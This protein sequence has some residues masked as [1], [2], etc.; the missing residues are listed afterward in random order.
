MKTLAR[1]GV[2]G[3]VIPAPGGL[4]ATRTKRAQ[5]IARR[6]WS[7]FD[8]L[9]TIRKAANEA[10]YQRRCA[11]RSD[12]VIFEVAHVNIDGNAILRLRFCAHAARRAV[13]TIC[14]SCDPGQPSLRR[15]RIKQAVTVG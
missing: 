1:N 14:V 6:Q 2:G 15:C 7:I 10:P 9:K 13:F 5:P 3:S 8:V 11:C 4:S 12:D